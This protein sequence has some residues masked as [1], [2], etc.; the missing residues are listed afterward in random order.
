MNSNFFN[1]NKRKKRD[2]LS[3]LLTD[4]SQDGII[5][6]KELYALHK[7]LENSSSLKAPGSLNKQTKEA[8]KSSGEETSVKTEKKLSLFI[9]QDIYNNLK[10]A[11]NNL[12]Q[13]IPKNMHPSISE[14]LLVNLSLA[15][16]LQELR[17]KGKNSRIFH[18]LMQKT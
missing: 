6:K 5:S 13:L 10:R 16:I 9:D 1:L 18:K 17:D 8:K 3:D 12:R 11:Q 4:I 14:S 2:I 7:L 15:I